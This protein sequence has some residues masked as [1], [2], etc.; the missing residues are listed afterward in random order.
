[1][2][3]KHTGLFPEQA[4]NWDFAQEQIAQRRAAHQCAEPVRLHRRRD[5]RLCG[6]GG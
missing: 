1:M 4:A 3:F 2:N 5:G 6:G